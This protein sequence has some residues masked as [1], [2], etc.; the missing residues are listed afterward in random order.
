MATAIALYN[1]PKDT[2]AFDSY[3]VSTH[4]PLA[5]KMLGLRSYE[6]NAGPITTP[7]A[8]SPY[9]LIAVLKFDT[10]SDLQAALASAQGQAVV[11]DLNNFATGGVSVLFF[12]EQPV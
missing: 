6:I 1:T 3:Y 12:D 9:Y 2:N 7:G 4:V 8:N 10:M 11:A 5:K